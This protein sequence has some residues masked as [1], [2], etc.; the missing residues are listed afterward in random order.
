MQVGAIY[1]HSAELQNKMINFRTSF[2]QFNNYTSSVEH[3]RSTRK[4]YGEN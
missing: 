2:N 1:E 4:H 3:K